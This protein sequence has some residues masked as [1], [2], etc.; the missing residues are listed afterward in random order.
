MLANVEDLE[1]IEAHNMNS[2]TGNGGADFLLTRVNVTEAGASPQ[3]QVVNIK[4]T[5]FLFK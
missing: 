1:Q 3:L 4:H 5:S 2:D